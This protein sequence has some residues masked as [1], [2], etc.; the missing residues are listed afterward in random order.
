MSSDCQLA[1][2]GGCQEGWRLQR[3]GRGGNMTGRLFCDKF[4][5]DP[6]IGDISVD[7]PDL[8]RCVSLNPDESSQIQ[9]ANGPLY[10]IPWPFPIW[11]IWI[12]MVIPHSMVM[13]DSHYDG[14]IMVMSGTCQ[15][16][17]SPWERRLRRGCRRLAQ[18]GSAG[19]ASIFRMP[20][21]GETRDGMRDRCGRWDETGVFLSKVVGNGVGN[22]PLR[23]FEAI[24]NTSL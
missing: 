18:P 7:S 12:N 21:E 14:N 4:V 5:C 1:M 17:G 24:S 22:R 9:V 15:V 13:V 11:I 16:D 10:D 2:P 8:R 20:G 3:Q 23:Q 19:A 6:G